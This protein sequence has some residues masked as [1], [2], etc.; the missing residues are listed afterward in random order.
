MSS[1]EPNPNPTPPPVWGQS[2]PPMYPVS[3]YPAPVKKKRKWVLPVVMLTAGLIFGG[4]VGASQVPEPVVETRIEEKIVT[5]TVEVTPKDCITALDLAGVLVEDL[6]QAPG[7]VGDALVAAY[8]RDAPAI[9]A[10]AERLKESKAN[11]DKQKEPLGT[12]VSACR[13]KAK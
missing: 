9:N 1:T 12:A 3:V 7:I 6:S 4:A 13:L 10:V 11:L 8:D 5:K 2:Q